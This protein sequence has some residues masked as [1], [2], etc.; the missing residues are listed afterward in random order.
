M[1]KHPKESFYY[2][3]IRSSKSNSKQLIIYVRNQLTFNFVHP[4]WMMRLEV[5]ENKINRNSGQ[6]DPCPS[7]SF[8]RGGHERQ[9]EEEGADYAEKNGEQNV[10][11]K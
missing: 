10:E 4:F 3:S 1:R 9:D 2:P 11:L 7:E 6:G 5:D 8:D